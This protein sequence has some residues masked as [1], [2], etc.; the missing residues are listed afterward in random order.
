MQAPLSEG[1]VSLAS[2]APTTK[3]RCVFLALHDDIAR[4]RSLG[5]S[6]ARLS[7][8]FPVSMTEVIS[9]AEA[10]NRLP[11][12]L[13]RLQ[14]SILEKS[15]LRF[16]I[17][18]HF[19]YVGLLLIATLLMFA[20]SRQL[21]M[22]QM[23]VIHDAFNHKA[24]F[25]PFFMQ[26]PGEIWMPLALATLIML[27]LVWRNIPL[28]SERGG[29]MNRAIRAV[30]QVLPV[31]GPVMRLRD[32]GQVAEV[33][34]LS[35]QASKTATETLN[36]AAG[37]D[38]GT[39]MREAI[40]R[41]AQSVEKG[42]AP[43]AALLAERAAFPKS[44][45]G[46]LALSSDETTLAENLQQAARAMRSEAVRRANLLMEVGAPLAV[47]VIGLFIFFWYAAMFLPISQLS[48]VVSS[49]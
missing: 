37:L 11:D 10:S 17:G 21:V 40:Q 24:S 22:T 45:S 30:F 32:A 12:A 25:L 27:I 8:F 36:R 46:W 9:A 38:V 2:D 43:V 28:L 13:L 47:C 5:E 23:T 14:D 3:L 39:P 1:L 20:F 41:A 34:A 35:L 15:S 16:A 33:L 26:I 4:G 48:L 44:F 31:I 7:A 42:I 18:S 29:R 49:H 6:M 19:M